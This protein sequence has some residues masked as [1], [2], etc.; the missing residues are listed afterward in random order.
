MNV[1]QQ[2]TPGEAEIELI[3]DTAKRFVVEEVQPYYASWEKRGHPDREIWRKAGALGLLCTMIPPAFGGFGGDIRHAS[4]LIEELM[5]SGCELH[6][7]Y[8]HSDVVVP[9]IA[10]LGTDEQKA[11]WLPGCVS[12][13]VVTCI[14]ITEPAAGSDMRGLQTRATRVDDHWVISGQKIFI[15]NGWLAD[16][17]IIVAN[18]GD[19]SNAKSLFL[20]ETDRPGFSRSQPLEKVGQKAQDT[21]ALFMDEVRVP[22]DALLGDVGKGLSHLMQ[23]LPTERLLVAIAATA[24]AE[25]VLG[26]TLDY[27]RERKAFG[28]A[29]ADFQANRF[30][31]AELK[32]EIEV[33]RAYVEKC[34]AQSLNGTL[35]T[36]KASVAKLWLSEMQ[37]RVVDRCVQL[38]GGYGYMWEYPVARA[39]ANARAQRIYGGSNDIMKEI[40]ARDM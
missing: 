8:T 23:E 34:V 17:A 11:R 4:V 5:R 18:T 32:A 9:Y 25:A 38:H 3:R 16:L 27:T 35:T 7:F 40:I 31:L 1:Y 29:I 37:G 36:A 22:A 2:D 39:F 28:K 12:G 24:I 10:R 14:G 6:G 26:W 19:G 30:A 20:V 33:G 13:D 15:T 21:V